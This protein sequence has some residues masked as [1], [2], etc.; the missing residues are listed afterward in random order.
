[1]HFSPEQ[2]QLGN[3]LP[4]PDSNSS[5]NSATML[6]RDNRE[7]P[8]DPK[9]EPGLLDN[10]EIPTALEPEPIAPHSE[11]DRNVQDNS[12]QDSDV[13]YDFSDSDSIELYPTQSTA[14][15]TLPTLPPPLPPPPPPLPEDVYYEQ[16]EEIE[17]PITKR[18]TGDTIVLLER[19]YS[20]LSLLAIPHS[21]PEPSLYGE[22]DDNLS[23]HIF[24]EHVRTLFQLHPDLF[25]DDRTKIM[26]A[27]CYLEP[28]MLSLFQW[29]KEKKWFENVEN[30]ADVE[31][32]LEEHAEK[33]EQSYNM[34]L[35]SKRLLERQLQTLRNKISSKNV[36]HG[37][38]IHSWN[39]FKERFDKQPVSAIQ[40]LIGKPKFYWQRNSAEEKE[41]LISE[42]FSNDTDPN[43]SH[44]F[45]K[46]REGREIPERIR[47]NSPHLI[48][49]LK[50]INVGVW[51]ESSFEEPVD[52]E[53][54]PSVVFLRP[55]KFLYHFR[56][57]I[58]A[59]EKVLEERL[60]TSQGGPRNHQVDENDG[61]ESSQE[62]QLDETSSSEDMENREDSLKH[63]RKLVEFIQAAVAP[64]AD[65]LRLTADD[66]NAPT[67]VH[68]QDL[69]YLFRPGDDVYV[70]GDISDHSQ[71]KKGSK[72]RNASSKPSAWRVL[73]I[74]D[75]RPLLSAGVENPTGPPATTIAPFVIA[76]YNIDYNGNISYFG[77]TH[78][79]VE[80]GHFEGEKEITS[81][82]AVPMR[83]NKD[84]SLKLRF[85]RIGEKFLR[86]IKDDYVHQQY[87]GPTLTRSPTGYEYPNA[88]KAML[89]RERVMVDF[90][91]GANEMPPWVPRLCIPE[92]LS[93]D[94]F[95]LDEA[96]PMKVWKK[97]DD[98]TWE[99]IA[100]PE[101]I[102]NDTHIDRALMWKYV[103]DNKLLNRFEKWID[104]PMSEDTRLTKDHILEEDIILLP[105]RV[106][107]FRYSRKEYV[108]ITVEELEDLP[109]S[110]DNWEEVVFNDN[111]YRTMLEA[112]VKSHSAKRG[113]I[114]QPNHVPTA[115]PGH[116]LVVG[117]GEG[118]IILLHGGPGVSSMWST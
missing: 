9:Q 103:E 6:I 64:I 67:R 116:D 43:L 18:S 86:L 2:I 115:K 75:G 105:N 33:P 14:E 41:P 82:E 60:S 55:Y 92:E 24:I 31:R 32:I 57:E 101:N 90:Q 85:K 54:Q 29:D 46:W 80:I 22:Q 74:T 76:L 99:S 59:Q 20:G 70:T 17:S 13:F 40:V 87:T 91:D 7:I 96:W 72:D 16:A 19:L 12:D 26:F 118:L 10:D 34:L 94:E 71:T 68:F 5:A 44:W 3:R 89:V 84:P 117:K 63:L 114:Y 98:N 51:G 62:S 97:K 11:D 93:P 53:G 111:I 35:N 50:K 79:R 78:R 106:V 112:L 56:S 25:R 47:I 23:F 21:F 100:R 77:P 109:E 28:E 8:E 52:D 108:N 38:A 107:A 36:A 37:M 48:Q 27:L 83:F 39:Q 110:S 69:W 73:N 66:A 30:F 1:M 104:G 49:I 113:N 88:S 58:R 81:L 45:E 15:P 65:K 42:D 95:T 61:D 102:Y 4:E